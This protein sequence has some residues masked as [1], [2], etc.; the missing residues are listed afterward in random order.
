[1]AIINLYETEQYSLV[2][3]GICSYYIN[4]FLKFVFPLDID[5]DIRNNLVIDG[6]SDEQKRIELNRMLSYVISDRLVGDDG[7]IDFGKLEDYLKFIVSNGLY[8]FFISL[9]DNYDK[10]CL[11][12]SMGLENTNYNKLYSGFENVVPLSDVFDYIRVKD[13]IMTLSGEGIKGFFQIDLKVLNL[14]SV[15]IEDALNDGEDFIPSSIV[16]MGEDN[17]KK[18]IDY[19]LWAFDMIYKNKY[20]NGFIKYTL[21]RECIIDSIASNICNN[22]EK[23]DVGLDDSYKLVL[24]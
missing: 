17:F 14:D 7:L 1:M 21:D 22:M 19:Y 9:K 5:N 18:I 8:D 2:D 4:D 24:R 3:G 23:D 20:E 11:G 15:I 10:L 13:G 16:S 6:A 12:I